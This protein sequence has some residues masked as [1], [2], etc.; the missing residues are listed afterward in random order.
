MEQENKPAEDKK[1]MKKK[2]PMQ[3]IEIEKIVINC[4][5][6]DEKLEKSIKLLK[7]ITKD[8]KIYQISSTRRIPAFGISPGKKSGC[9]VTLRNKEQIMDLLKRFFA[10][11]DYE[12]SG[13]K[14][15]ENHLSFG[16]PEYIEVPGLEYDRDIGI[17]GF[18][19]SVVFQ[20]KGKRVKNKKI[21]QGKYP[22]KQNVT[23]EE[24]IEFLNKHVGVEII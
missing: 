1:E 12:L 5:G 13:K 18:E 9:K 23:K 3:E 22:K 10:G 14:I 16:I 19:V 6:T 17:L 24:I 11:I 4:G 2:N 20:R 7:M 21:K 15:V 8:R